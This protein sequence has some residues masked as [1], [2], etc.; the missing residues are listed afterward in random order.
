M[1]P[2]KGRSKTRGKT[3]NKKGRG[4]KKQLTMFERLKTGLAE[5]G[6]GV[7]SV[8]AVGL[9][10]IAVLAVVML[11]AGGYFSNIGTR[12]DTLT[13][14][15]AKAMGFSVT[16]VSLY[17]SDQLSNREIML[18]LEDDEA[19]SVLGRSLLHVDA[20]DARQKIE[21]LGWVQS[22]AV[23][24]LWPN[25]VHI[26]VRERR[27]AAL[28]QDGAGRYHLIDL[29]GALIAEVPPVEHTDLPVVAGSSSPETAIPLLT[30][31]YERPALM[32]RVAVVM[33]VGDR[34]FDL[35]F[36]NDFTA[37]LPEGPAG[38]ALDRLEG[39]GAGTGK[40][41]ETL[42]YIDLRDPEWAYLKPK[43]S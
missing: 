9:A 13:G 18:A 35:R 3:A 2:V 27:P 30:A 29:S 40:L 24:R 38:P 43:S 15:A 19:G 34:R 31:L 36:R 12:I 11:M 25:T 1:P 20:E 17:G 22:A 16:R 41:S 28:W 39:L 6:A 10:A 8:V 32:S 21:R 14:R 26:S 4:R 37:R 42:D 33:S 7:L 5:L 23:E